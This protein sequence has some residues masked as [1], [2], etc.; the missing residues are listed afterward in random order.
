MRISQKDRLLPKL[1]LLTVYHFLFAVIIAGCGYTTRSLITSS[2]KTIYVRPF[3]NKI[4]ITEETSVARR[5]QTYHPLLENDITRRLIDR[6]ILDGNLRLAKEQDADLILSGELIDY[7]REAL[8]YTG[9]DN[10][11]VEEY[12]IDIVVNIKL[13]DTSNQTTL[14]KEDNFIGDTTYFTEGSESTAIRTAVEDLSRRIVNRVVDV[15]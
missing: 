15:W 2:Y 5:Y 1:F 13:Y 14:W 7:R 3:V 11:N 8:R 10:K 6:F 9:T 4:D 12:R